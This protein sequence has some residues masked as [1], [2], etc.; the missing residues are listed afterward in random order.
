VMQYLKMYKIYCANQPTALKLLET[1]QQDNAMFAAFLQECLNDPRCKGQNLFSY[2]IKPIQRLC[3][4][5]LLIK[6]LLENTDP[7]HPDYDNLDKALHEVEE[8]VSYVNEGKRQAEKSQKIL[9]IALATEGGESLGFVTP[10]RNLEMETT[11][12]V[13]IKK[14]KPQTRKCMLFND[15]VMLVKESKKGAK[16]YCHPNLMGFDQI[17]VVNLSDTEELK[18]VIELQY[19]STKEKYDL[20][21]DTEENKQR[22]LKEIKRIVKIYQL[23][24]LEEL[25]KEDE[26]RAS[27]PPA[28]PL[29]S[30]PKYFNASSVDVLSHTTSATANN[31]NNNNI[32]R[33]NSLPASKQSSFTK[34]HP[35][36]ASPPTTTKAP[37]EGGGA[38][39]RFAKLGRRTSFNTKAPTSAIKPVQ[40][41]MNGSPL[42]HHIKGK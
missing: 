4:Y 18:H 41:M 3:K 28:V 31:V 5:P 7:T 15:A 22:W 19:S 2:L 36:N 25:K 20:I 23:K 33:T 34:P 30:V 21:F 29:P 17:K 6:V 27:K 16:L 37:S 12:E 11:L 1:Q 8:I 38:F 39:G 14:G 26:E 24:K 9:E 10:T 42:P 32:R 13:I 40:P 35:P